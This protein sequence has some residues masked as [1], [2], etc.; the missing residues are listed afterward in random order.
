VK[1]ELIFFII[2]HDLMHVSDFPQTVDD[3]M[4]KRFFWLPVEV[5]FQYPRD[6]TSIIE[7]R[8]PLIYFQV[9]NRKYRCF[10][11][12]SVKY[13]FFIEKIPVKYRFFHFWAHPS[14]SWSGIN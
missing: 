12:G 2:F 6:R 9:W 5:Q 14:I 4:K 7:F 3:I 11:I 13:R 10:S 8:L 1:N